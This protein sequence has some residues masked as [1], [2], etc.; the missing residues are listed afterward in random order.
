M[1][2]S[3]DT[4]NSLIQAHLLELT[5]EDLLDLGAEHCAIAGA[6][7]SLAARRA[8][9]A[10]VDRLRLLAQRLVAS[11]D[12]VCNRYT[13]RRFQIEVAVCSQSMRLTRAQVH[14]Q[15][16]LSPLKWLLE[17]AVD[18]KVEAAGHLALVD[19]IQA[20]DDEAA[21]WLAESHS[22]A[23]IRQLVALRTK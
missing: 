15:E 11:D 10:E 9:P 5:V 4:V 3:A 1:R 23:T 16:E 13:D 21:R 2:A 18:V 22:A 8:V 20:E 19:A 14:L 6:T 12:P 7:A 17:L